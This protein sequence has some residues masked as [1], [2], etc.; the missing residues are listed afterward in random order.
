MCEIR[1]SQK[2]TGFL[3]RK[4]P[5]VR[6]VRQI[7]QAQWGDFC[8]QALALLALQKAAEAYAVNLFE[9][10]NLY[11]IH[12]KRVALIPKDIQL[13]QRIWEDTVK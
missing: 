6:W 5:F 2:S 7:A 3:I 4:L 10:A 1:K 9:D 13:A 11:T 8:F 12:A